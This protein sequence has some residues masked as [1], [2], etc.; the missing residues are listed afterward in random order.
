MKQKNLTVSACMIVKNEELMLAQCLNSIS[1]LVDEIV[2]VDTGSTDRTVEIAESF[3]ATIYHHQWED[4]FSRHRNQSISHATGEWIFV[5]DAD[6][7]L[8]NCGMTEQDLHQILDE[9]PQDQNALL[10]TVLDKNRDKEVTNRRRQPRFFRNNTG[11]H[12]SGIV[13]NAPEYSGTVG[14]TDI[15]LIHHGYWLSEDLMQDKLRRKT[16]LLHRR[17]QLNPC[18]YQAYFYLSQLYMEMRQDEKC[19]EY[20]EKCLSLLNKRIDSTEEHIGFYQTVYHILALSLINRERYIDAVGIIQEGLKNSP[21][22]SVLYYDLACTGYFLQDYKLVMEGGDAFFKCLEKYRAIASSVEDAT[23]DFIATLTSEAISALQ[24]WMMKACLAENQLA[25][26]NKL[27]NKTRHNFSGQPELYEE[28]LSSLEKVNAWHDLKHALD[29]IVI[30]CSRYSEFTHK[31]VLEYYIY[32]FRMAESYRTLDNCIEKYLDMITDYSQMPL[33]VIVIIAESM[34]RQNK[35]R[36]F[37]EISSA[38]IQ[39]HVTDPPDNVR[40]RDGLA[41]SYSLLLKDHCETTGDV[42]LSLSILNIAWTLTDDQSYLNGVESLRRNNYFYLSASA[43][44]VNEEAQKSSS[45]LYQIVLKKKMAF[46]VRPGL[47]SFIGDIIT[48]LSEKYDTRKIIITS[49]SQIDSIVQWADICWF[50]WCDDLVI[51]ATKFDLL[52]GKKVVCRLHSYEAFTDYPAKVNW[53]SVDRVIFVAD[54]IRNIVVENVSSLDREKTIVIPNGIDCTKYNFRNREPGFNIAYLGYINYKKGPMLL[55]HLFKAIHDIDS[56]YKLYIAGTFQDNRYILYFRQMIEEMG[57]QSAVFHD[58][59]QQNVDKWLEDKNYIVST[60]LLESQALCIMEGMS[61]GIK[62]LIH[63]FVGAREIY[64][65]KY[66]WNTI[67]E[68]TAMLLSDSYDSTDYRAFIEKRYSIH[69]Q[70]GAVMAMIDGLK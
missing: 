23:A 26:Y 65:E 45:S 28:I 37:L 5:I 52:K 55:L 46:L 30:N 19:I 33:S 58:G 54:H 31:K 7:E 42:L 10:V 39:L 20:A 68:C 66:L 50:E 64:S 38:V 11:V 16:Y 35:G 61:K 48:H 36:I 15:E 6:E 49:N 41:L 62:P 57:L 43:I 14:Y 70:M 25:I 4:D 40:S 44:T 3:N 12:Y 1:R 24:F 18:D 47:D 13:H 59:W 63:N 21:D 56:R 69:Q 34:L 9:V 17:V 2:L 29:F 27:W 67:P 22:Q 8:Y 60:S 32:I 53:K 51:H